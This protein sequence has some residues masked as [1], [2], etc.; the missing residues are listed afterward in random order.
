[1]SKLIVSLS[2]HIHANDSVEKN[3]RNVI[4][5]LLPVL[6]VS[7]AYFGIGAAIVC[8]TSVAACL[9]FEWVIAHVVMKS[10]RN[11]LADGSAVVTGL[12]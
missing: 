10:K 4:I 6:G 11:T 12:L 5:A 8:A 9:F 1:M 7:V 3:M 2:P